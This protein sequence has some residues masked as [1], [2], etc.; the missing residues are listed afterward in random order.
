MLAWMAYA[1][2][3]IISTLV[4]DS[5]QNR[6]DIIPILPRLL[7]TTLF[8]GIGIYIVRTHCLEVI[9]R[10]DDKMHEKKACITDTV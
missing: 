6:E 8:Y 1:G 7:F 4:I 10:V 3:F 9:E 5:I 2:G